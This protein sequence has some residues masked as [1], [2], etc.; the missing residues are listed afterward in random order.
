MKNMRN[1]GYMRN[2][3][4]KKFLTTLSAV[5]A[6]TLSFSL[7]AVPAHA[8]DAS[9]DGRAGQTASTTYDTMFDSH[10]ITDAMWEE[11]QQR[12]IDSD[13]P[14]EQTQTAAGT[15]YVFTLDP[16]LDGEF[17]GFTVDFAFTVGAEPDGVIT[18][19]FGWGSDQHGRYF[20][21]NQTDQQ[22]IASG[23]GIAL[24]TAL[25][26]IPGAG[27]VSCVGIQAAIA[28]VT[29]FMQTNTGCS[30]NLAAYIDRPRS[31]PQYACK[32]Y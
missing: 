25:C 22:A 5:A 26:A 1:K 30:E 13:L 7:L 32:P 16:Q 12:L 4:M 6:A 23:A 8:A 28:A 31:E 14:R 11:E 10:G 17:E 3:R 18:P 21:F 27:W 15:H 24:G 19:Y 2:S 9:D 20:L 29:I